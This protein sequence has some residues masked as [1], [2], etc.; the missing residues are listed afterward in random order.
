MSNFTNMVLENKDGADNVLNTMKVF[1]EQEGSVSV[2]TFYD[3][4]GFPSVFLDMK[5]GWTSLEGVEV[6]E[7]DDGF[8]LTLP[9]PKKLS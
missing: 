7:E 1:V 2:Q 4:I 3:L 9:D 8:V 6:K 5:K